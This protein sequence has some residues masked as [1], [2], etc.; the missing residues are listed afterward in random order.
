MTPR[1]QDLIARTDSVPAPVA[2]NTPDPLT[3]LAQVGAFLSA[4]S[5]TYESLLELLEVAWVQDGLNVAIQGADDT[6]MTSKQSL[7]YMT[8]KHSPAPLGAPDSLGFLDRAHRFLRLWLATGYK[9]WE[10]DLLLGAAAVGNGRLDEQALA[11]LLCFRQLQD[12]TGLAVD[13]LLAFYQ[14]I[15]IATHR[16][17][18][19]TTTASLYARIF[20]NTAVTSVAPDPDLAALATGGTLA[21]HDLNKHLAGIQ[22][23]LGVSAADAAT[24]FRLTDNRLTLANLSLIYRV[25][26][27]ARAAKLPVSDLLALARLL[28]PACT[29]TSPVDDSQTS[30]TVTSDTGFTPSSFPVAIGPEILLV[31]A[32]GGTRNTTWTVER[33]QQG[34]TPAAAEA[35]T[36]VA[37]TDGDVNRAALAPLFASPAATLSFLAQATVIQQASLDLDALTYLLTPPDAAGGWATTTTQMTQS[38][39]ATALGAV[40]QRAASLLSARTTLTSSIDARQTSITVA[41]DTG[42]TP[43]SFPVAIG[44]EILL[45]TAAGGTGN[46]TWTV[47]RG[48][49]GTTAAPAGEGTA[50]TPTARTTLTSPIDARQTSITVASNAG[51][52]APSFPVAIGPEILLVTAAG[53]TGNTTWTVERGQ[54]GTTAAPA[55]EGTA[56]TPTARTTLT[57]S[58]DA[59]QTSIT[60]TSDTGFTPSSFPVAIGPEILLVTAAGGTGNTTWTVERG[61]Q[62]TTAAPA[63]AG[64]PV[65]PTGGVAGATIA[66]V[67]AN[68][69][70]ASTSGLA[71]DVSALILQQLRVPG[72]GMTLLAV[73]TDPAFI[74]SGSAITQASFP[75]QF[76]AIQLFDKAAVLVRGLRL[77]ASDLTWLLANA[78]VYG[79][80]DFTQLPVTSGRAA[81]SLPPLLTTLLVIKL[82]RLWTAAPPSS[83]VQTL[84]DVI[85][86]VSNPT[87]PLTEEQAR[88]A[89]ATITGWPPPDVDAFAKALGLDFPGDYQQPTAYDALRTLEAM[90]ATAGATGPQIVDWGAVPPDEPAAK[91]IAAGALGVL[92]A[93]QPSNDAWLTLSPTL[94]NPIRENRSAALQAYLI[95]QRDSS[96][97]LIYADAKGLFD[98]F[99]IDVQMSSCQVT[100]RVVQ[101][102]VAVQ[103]FVERCLMNLEA[104]EVVVDMAQHD[105]W[106]QWKWMS[107]YRI[108]QANREVFLYPEN[109]LIESQR[110]NRTEIYQKLEQEV[111]QGQLTAGYL[112]TVVLNY[113]DR[114]DGLAHLQVT[115]TCQDPGDPGENIYVAARTPADPPVFYLRS[116][117]DGAWTGWTQ[118]P[119]NINAYH[120]VPALYRGRVCL[121]WLDVKV[122]NE[123]QQ[124]MP[125][126]KVSDTPPSQTAD[127]Y[128]SLGIN[129]STLRNGSW[130]PAQ[131]ATGKL[132][133]KPFYN[134]ALVSDATTVAGLY[135]LKIRPKQGYGARLFIDV[136]RLGDFKADPTSR[137]T[138][139]DESVAVHLGQAV[140]DGRFSDLELRDLAVPAGTLVKG[141]PAK[142]PSAVHLLAHA[143]EAYGPAAQALLPLPDDQVDRD[144]SRRYGLIL[145]AGALT[146]APDYA[147]QSVFWLNFFP[148]AEH[149]VHSGVVL[150]AAPNPW[151]IVGPGTDTDFDPASY[152]FFADNRRCYWVET[153]KLY[154]VGSDWSP[155]KPSD[156]NSVYK[157]VYIFHPF[158]YPFTGLFWNQ[159]AGGGFAQLYDPDLQ[160]APD[161]IDP[162]SDLFSF[163]SG[164]LASERAQWD[165]ASVS[166]TLALPISSALQTDITVT[167][168][169]WVP[170]PAFWIRI[171]TEILKVTGAK[172]VPGV[173]GATWTVVRG[174]GNPWSNPSG[175]TSPAK[176]PGG[177]A[178]TAVTPVPA[179][180]WANFQDRQF[181]DFS[182][183]A[184]FSAY[185]WE[186]FYHIPLYTA[187]LLSQNQQ[188]EDAQTWL[189]YIFN[190]TYKGSDPIPQRFWIPKPLHNLT[191]AGILQQQINNL[192]AAVN[193][194]DP[195]SVSTINAWRK[196]PF[197][198]FVLADLRPV[199]YMKAA[200]MS[201]LD[202]LIAWADNLFSTESREALGEATLLYVIA[203]E[204]LG[205]QPAAITPPQH[206]DKSFD[207]LEAS[208]DAFANAFVEIE[209]VI[210]GTGGSVG[211]AGGTG[212]GIP[213]PTFYFKIPSN[214]RLL[215]YWTTVADRLYKLRHCQ[216]IA[217]APLQ[218]ALFDAPIDPGLL[219]AARAAGVDLSSV[220]SDVAVALPNYRFTALYPQAL[221][222][223]NAVRAYGSSL[224]AALEKSD[225]GA[226]VLLQQTARRQLL[227]DGSQ[228]LDWQVQQAQA[229]LEALNEALNL[230]QQKYDANNSQPLANA[231][232]ISA[233]K[234]KGAALDL[235]ISSAMLA[236]GAAVAAAFPKAT[237]GGAGFGGSPVVAETFGGEQISAMLEKGA[238]SAATLADSLQIGADIAT[239]IGAWNQ[240]REDWDEAAEEARI[241]IA[242]TQAQ[243]EAAT[244][245]VQIAQQ[246]KTVYQERI[247]NIQKQID[248]LNSKF[249]SDSLYDWMTGMLSATYFQSYQLAYQMC[250]QLER[251]YQFELGIQDS[252]FIQFGYW[253]SLHKGLLAGETLNRDLRRMQAAYLQ[254][255][256]RRYELSRYVSLGQLD[257]NALRQLLVTGQCDFSLPESLFDNDYPGHYNRRLTRVSLTV[258]YPSP[259]KFDNVKA[260]LTMVTNQVRIST[261]KSAGYAENPAGSDKRFQYNYAAVPQ[262]I[263]MSNAQDDPGLFITAIDG[264]ITDQRYVPFENAGA[265]SSWHLETPQIN[266][267]VDVSTVTDVVLHLYYTALDGGT[268]F[269]AAVQKNNA[270]HAPTSGIKVFSA[271]NDFPARAPTTANPYP[272]TPWQAFLAT[273]AAP[274]NQV[275][276]L[277]I[278]PSKFPPWTRGKT[279]SVTSLTVLA[280]G[281][282]PGNFVLAPQAPLPTDAVVMKP[283]EG[284]P[285]PNVC[286]PTITMPDG[287]PPGTWSFQ[288]RQE[289]V[290]DFR[291]LTENEIGDVTLLVSYQVS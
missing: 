46:T 63:A 214:S 258:L 128:V 176:A 71:N 217:G 283:V 123:P 147:S 280:V 121:F 131:A 285:W 261:D 24:L 13:H 5:I 291:S 61:Q 102:Y 141:P 140:F 287:T 288:L 96:G 269:Q 25:T 1:G 149:Q 145:Q 103:T 58:I 186:L 235:K 215:G 220:L 6:C 284:V 37:G 234:L 49:Q 99:L 254:Q 232:E 137:I 80:L 34:T 177:T 274:A 101:A 153:Q 224:Q 264:N 162:S 207:Q 69:R 196:N 142:A 277:S 134:P 126:A 84:Y 104:P 85:S 175:Q 112:E 166:T 155:K 7:T 35:G 279:L 160:Q 195:A 290:P 165:L 51:F 22:A 79:G 74:A 130:A 33:G 23:A 276:T 219:I 158:Y 26:T 222:F 118:I 52:P 188:F 108:W 66:A 94:M 60:V 205:P 32:A 182:Y 119:L 50:V 106:D 240:R 56:V 29:L 136:F 249:T 116:F 174:Q 208:L 86:G 157:V 81:V 255:N 114:L 16:D 250:K 139:V 64:T 89:L 226:L 167:N 3:H 244:F 76:L 20:L 231:D 68:A 204:I 225:A 135:T 247:D 223:V 42:F 190:P 122:S 210:G 233:V 268:D 47:E 282:A 143:K 31:T 2:W 55:G 253:D 107:R 48:Q 230:A 62:G 198:P 67:A 163:Q 53:G 82:A 266:N 236:A 286:A 271:Q 263:A 209:N 275:L 90:A 105:T 238:T 179:D 257:L 129:F 252:S 12:A 144:V 218:L 156:P 228:I 168:N 173:K 19:G 132:F 259:G 239:T 197:N 113:L 178:V 150:G 229:D 40:R 203:S 78:A 57:S 70:T 185:N 41:S 213:V 192:L 180:D 59:R 270:D 91:G 73:L 245:A 273:V 75:S 154:W 54:Q 83:P 242:E 15:D 201:Y 193:Q 65:T 27:L 111:H 117:A 93:Q 243:I 9:M 289:G 260:T 148:S 227:R 98:Y 28:N 206:A 4:A 189:K 216:N 248:F 87:A 95:A 43:S 212:T 278:S 39:I 194:G 272:P 256:A 109:W 267:E 281:R 159:L 183:A 202:N 133:D 97:A 36:V 17:P 171:G 169:I 200:V 100:S 115:G 265:I 184:S 246:N 127:R 138:D 191:S 10:L 11:A 161:S 38:A 187:Q 30:I 88:R 8:S 152:F 251:C 241:Q 92:K 14:D 181:L 21:D 120:A 151:R 199:A 172:Q 221:D 125:P 45:V 18:D 124:V 170:L 77:V 164:Y 237:A 262:K 110:P 44:P 211:S 146:P 72:T